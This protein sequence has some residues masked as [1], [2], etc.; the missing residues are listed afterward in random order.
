MYYVRIDARF[1]KKGRKMVMKK[2]KLLL[3]T[4]LLVC[5]LAITPYVVR[6]DDTGSGAGSSEEGAGGSENGDQGGSG[7]QTPTTPPKNYIEDGTEDKVFSSVEAAENFFVNT[8][9]INFTY[10]AKDGTFKQETISVEHAMDIN[11]AGAF[12]QGDVTKVIVSNVGG[13]ISATYMMDFASFNPVNPI[14]PVSPSSSGTKASSG[15][16]GGGFSPYM[17]FAFMSQSQSMPVFDFGNMFSGQNAIQAPSFDFGNM[18]GGQNVMQAPS[19][20]FGNV[21]GGQSTMQ[22]PSFDFG[23]M[24]GGQGTMQFPNFDFGNMFGGQDG[25]MSFGFDFASMFQQTGMEGFGQMDMNAVGI[26]VDDMMNDIMGN[27]NGQ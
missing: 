5:G 15:L 2:F 20:D 16:S 12:W 27:V 6:A 9:T 18:F 21:F 7:T 24:F 13:V 14:Q 1:I 26:N 19:F 25:S 4:G 23:N 22:F 3:A 8:N 10:M 17:A 11:I